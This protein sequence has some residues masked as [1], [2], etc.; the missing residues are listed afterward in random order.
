[1]QL[2]L[3]LTFTPAPFI[4]RAIRN[5]TWQDAGWA[6]A[7]LGFTQKVEISRSLCDA[8]DHGDQ[9]QQLYD[10]LWL[11]HHHLALL[12]RTSFSFTFDRGDGSLRLHVEDRGQVVLLGLIQ[13]F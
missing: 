9:D 7:C 10:A 8:L 2:V 12:Q 13:D 3:N 1:M 11:T 4:K 5:N 6:C